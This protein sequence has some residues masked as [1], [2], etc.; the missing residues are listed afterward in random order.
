MN[1]QLS[2]FTALVFLVLAACKKNTDL[3][4][5]KP[6]PLLA[7][8]KHTMQSNQPYDI[9][10]Q[11]IYDSSNRLIEVIHSGKNTADAKEKYTYAGNKI[12]YRHYVGTSETLSAALDYTL[13]DQGR[14]EKTYSPHFNQTSINEFNSDG[15]ITRINYLFNTTAAGF[16]RHHYGAGHLLDS[17]T[18][19]AADGTL[20][21]VHVF[22]YEPGKQN[23]ISD[24]NKGLAALGRATPAPVRRR[25]LYVYDQPGKDGIRMKYYELDYSYEFDGQ[26]RIKKH[27]TVQTQYGS[28]GSSQSYIREVMEYTY[29]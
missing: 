19:F 2:I 20:K 4:P 22:T 25:T 26:G 14:A 28:N 24:E 5:A 12:L 9:T 27:T 16:Q 7:T 3:A 18:G 15:Y 1:R 29:K 8:I 23:T 13:N 21:Y 17:I 11:F 10:R 6:A